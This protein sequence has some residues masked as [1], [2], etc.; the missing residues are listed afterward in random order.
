MSGAPDDGPRVLEY[1]ATSEKGSWPVAPYVAAVVWAFLT[2][3]VLTNEL[4]KGPRAMTR[5]KFRLA[6]QVALL[7]C[8]SIRLAWAVLRKE[9]GKGWVF[10]LVLLLLAA[11]LWV[12]AESLSE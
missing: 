3:R 11:P 2:L 8:A 12:M 6:I 1:C 7:S 9:K 4:P 5:N 10:Y